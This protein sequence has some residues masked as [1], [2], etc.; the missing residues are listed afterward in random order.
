M[1]RYTLIIPSSQLYLLRTWDPEL[2]LQG[3]KGTGSMGGEG[4]PIQFEFGEII[5]SETIKANIIYAMGNGEVSIDDVYKKIIEYV[6]DISFDYITYVEKK[7]KL[8]NPDWHTIKCTF[9]KIAIHPEI[10][11]NYIRDGDFPLGHL[12]R[13]TGSLKE[14]LLN[15]PSDIKKRFRPSCLILETEP[16][17]QDDGPAVFALKRP[18][19]LFS[20]ESSKD[21]E[22]FDLEYEKRGG[23]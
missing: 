1:S 8:G 11:N 13:V 9:K 5:T 23:P 16:D 3:F 6:P 4:S 20:I 19:M 12:H 15:I 17:I 2:T 7:C 14:T 18:Y 22:L 10:F 21:W